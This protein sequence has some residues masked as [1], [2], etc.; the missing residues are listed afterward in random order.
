MLI[1]IN[2]TFMRQEEAVISI[3]HGA[4]HYGTAAF[5]G[6]LCVRSSRQHIILRL[7]DHLAR[8]RASAALLGLQIPYSTAIIEQAIVKLI[9]RNNFGSCYIR[10][11]V[12]GNADYLRLVPKRQ[13]TVI[14]ILCE[15]MNSALFFL[16]MK[17]AQKVTVIDNMEIAWPRSLTQAKVSGKYVFS[18][19][20]ALE[21]R[22][23]GFDDAIMINHERKVL[24]ATTSNLFMIKDKIIYT[25]LRALTLN[26][27]VQDTVIRL[28]ADEGYTVKEK[29]VLLDGLY[30]ADEIFLSSTAG[31]IVS[32]KQLETKR[33]ISATDYNITKLLRDAYV[34]VITGRD[35]RYKHLLTCF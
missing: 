35:S 33:I 26:G 30:G 12:F 23:R 11:I 6:I 14:A 13:D 3:A 20:A 32:V 34:N 9:R 16:M 4:L 10:P 27:I 15:E 28:A 25:P 8:L 1:W 19:L 7:S 21:A 17:R 31:G 29:E 2:G 18:A 24:E 5:E 22:K